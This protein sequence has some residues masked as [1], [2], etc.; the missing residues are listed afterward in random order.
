[1]EEEEGEGELMYNVFDIRFEV[2]SN[3]CFTCTSSRTNMHLQ[4][5][6]VENIYI[7]D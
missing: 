2:I 1:M 4:I 6:V 3:M 7:L 5:V